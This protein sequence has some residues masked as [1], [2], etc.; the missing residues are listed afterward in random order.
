MIH[1]NILEFLSSEAKSRKEFWLI[2]SYHNNGSLSDYLKNNILSWKDFCKISESMA[3]GLMFLHEESNDGLKPSIAHRDFKS[4]NVILKDDLTACIADFGLALAFSSR[5]TSVQDHSQVGTKRYMAP[6][7]IEGAIDFKRHAF[8]RIDIYACGLVL[9]EMVSRC[10]AHNSPSLNYYLPFELELGINPSFHDLYE[11]VVQQ[12][13]RPRILDEWRTHKVKRIINLYTCFYLFNNI[14]F[15][16]INLICN[17]IEEC[18]DH[19]IEARITSACVMERMNEY[20]I[21]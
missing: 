20:V 2:S 18:W 3:S 8:L 11:T 19:N 14:P 9:W 21:L 16:G 12:K 5:D 1:P 10:N 6:E 15:Q 4:Q 13:M 7:V 17:T